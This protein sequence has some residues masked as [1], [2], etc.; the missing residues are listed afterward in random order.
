MFASLEYIANGGSLSGNFARGTFDDL[1]LHQAWVSE[2][3]LTNDVCF[4]NSWWWTA[5]DRRKFL[6]DQFCEVFVGSLR[7]KSFKKTRIYQTVNK[8]DSSHYHIKFVQMVSHHI[9]KCKSM[10]GVIKLGWTIL[11]HMMSPPMTSQYIVLQFVVLYW[12]TWF[13]HTALSVQFNE[14]V[15]CCDRSFGYN[16]TIIR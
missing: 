15:L 6:C 13:F 9:V 12:A 7:S 2:H 1:E 8:K 4:W 11:Y 10:L 16:T 5:W 3:R 14:S